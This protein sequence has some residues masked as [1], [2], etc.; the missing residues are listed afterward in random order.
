MI[1]LTGLFRKKT[2]VKRI[3]FVSTSTK[4]VDDDDV[5]DYFASII[6]ELAIKVQDLPG[7]PELLIRVPQRGQSA[8]AQQ[9]TFIENAIGDSNPF[10][11][12]IIS[13]VDRDR[14][15]NNHLEDW[16]TK[17]GHNRLVF[18]DQG[19]ATNEF[20]NFLADDVSRPPF[21]QA[22]WV[23]GGRVAG[24]SMRQKLF[25]EREVRYPHIILVKGL[26]GSPQRIEGFKEGMAG[27][28]SSVGC[29]PSYYECEGKYSK[30]TARETF[31]PYLLDCI[32]EKRCIHGVFATNDEMALAIRDAL[33]KNK[34]DYV[35]A[36]PPTDGRALLPVVIGFD[37]MRDLTLHIDRIDDF[38]YDTVY[39]G[40]KDQIQHLANIVE[41]VINGTKKIP[42][43][44]KFVVMNC[45]SYRSLKGMGV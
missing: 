23:Q 37:G 30:R 34:E 10:D 3:L 20:E 14:L 21:V 45:E 7:S 42:A 36:F 15:Y 18:V 43:A 5:N 16:I 32:K 13:P 4:S 17:V 28:G 8:S 25:E 26:I 24:N 6:P 33:A 44:E 1:N 27:D 11:C 9:V 38:I 19:F 39:V 35:A 22:D 12:I 2:A 41:K 31:E 40:L 29:Q